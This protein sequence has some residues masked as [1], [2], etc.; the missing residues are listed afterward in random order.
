MFLE[1]SEKN[2]YQIANNLIFSES[3]LWS[4]HLHPN[5]MVECFIQEMGI[6]SEKSKYNLEEK[7][8][9]SLSRMGILFLATSIQEGIN[10]LRK[11]QQYEIDK[12]N[13][14][15]Y[16]ISKILYGSRFGSQIHANN[17]TF[18]IMGMAIIKLD[19][20]Y[21]GA[22]TEVNMKTFKDNMSLR[23]YHE[24]ISLLYEKPYGFDTLS[25]WKRVAFSIGYL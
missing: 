7:T 18:L 16:V 3:K 11:N 4:K 6:N 21:R 15:N 23:N 25:G 13:F 8:Q 22:W 17:L 14:D 19:G 9:V 10:F 1:I 24:L 5:Q 12:E 20:I 2:I